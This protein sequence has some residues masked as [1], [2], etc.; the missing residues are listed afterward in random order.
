MAT[1][2][3]IL[4]I[5]NTQVQGGATSGVDSRMSALGATDISKFFDLEVNRI[6]PSSDAT[7]ASTAASLNWY[8][9]FDR[10]GQSTFYTVAA[11]PAPTSTTI[12]ANGA[13][14]GWTVNEWAGR[15]VAVLNS[16]TVGFLNFVSVVSNTA[17]TITVASWPGGTP[18]AGLLFRLGQGR[19]DDYHPATGHI[20]IVSELGTRLPRGGS[21]VAALGRGVGPDAGL[22]RQFLAHSYPT[23]PYFQLAKHAQISLTV[24]GWNAAGAT[25]TS[26]EAFLADCASAWTALANGNT[27]LWDCVIWDQSQADVIDWASNPA[28]Y[29]SYQSA[30]ETTIAYLRTALGNPDLKVL[31][32]NHDNEINNVTMPSGTLLANRLHRTIEASDSLV[33]TVSMQGLR[34]AGTTAYGVPSENKPFYAAHEYWTRYAERVRVAYDLLTAGTPVPID[35]ATPAYIFIGDSICVGAF[36][37]T[38]TDALASPTLTSGPRAAAQEIFNAVNGQGEAYDVGDNSNT[39]G[40]VSINAGP[41]CSMM[42]E[43]EALHP[44]GSLMVKRGSNSSCL[45]ASLS[46]YT[47]SGSSGGRWSHSISGEHWDALVDLW[48]AAEAY[49]WENGKQLDLKAIFVSLGTND[50]A[51]AGGGEL[52]A[53]ELATFVSDLR[54]TFATR[55]SGTDLPII[56]RK[57]QLDYATAIVDEIVAV[58]AAIEDYALADEQFLINDV[59]DL[60]RLATDNIHETGES[61]MIDGQRFVAALANI[62]I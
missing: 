30:L 18:T 51:V 48:A 28:H 17:D 34:L 13:S 8:P 19:W 56:W 10:S 16:T 11:S 35:T 57:P 59:D 3:G 9:W 32:V 39:S 7:G 31:I 60:E 22:I 23:A 1:V 62:A 12:T 27:L 42:V 21:S 37:S 41:E 33:R 5:G 29:L 58:R 52:F 36:N 40:T 53:A 49:S 46:A 20:F 14:P 26:F 43:L 55:T 38:Y 4:I 50:G 25:R 45:I 2:P 47:G 44:G 6:T 15:T 24:G 61:S 54:A